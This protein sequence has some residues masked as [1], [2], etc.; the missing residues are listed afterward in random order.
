VDAGQVLLG[1]LL[2]MRAAERKY[3]W[4]GAWRTADGLPASLRRHVDNGDP[5]D[6]AVL[7]AMLWARGISTK[8][9]EGQ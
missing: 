2:K 1:V 7:A 8:E 4:R 6:V 5:R 3:K 9:E